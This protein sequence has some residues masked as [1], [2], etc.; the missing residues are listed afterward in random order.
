MAALDVLVVGD[1]VPV[2]LEEGVHLARVPGVHTVVPRRRRD[3][4][5]R[6]H[7]DRVPRRCDVLVRAVLGDE[8]PLV[9]I[10]GISVLG[11]P[12]RP[13]QQAVIPLHVQERHLTHDGAERLRVL[14]EHD[15]HEQAAVAAALRAQLVR[16]GDAALHQIARDR[17]EVLVHLVSTGLQH[18]GVPRRPVLAAAADVRHHVGTAPS[19]P[20]RADHAA[21]RGGE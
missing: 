14:G 5:R 16:G 13:G 19:Q 21:V 9:G 3:E 10:V 1:V 17:R 4:D 20:G 8:G 18:L 7:T 2:L 15:A 6:I 12:R 11:H